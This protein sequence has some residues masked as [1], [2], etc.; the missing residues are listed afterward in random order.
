M[1]ETLTASLPPQLSSLDHVGLHPG[2]PG[3]V[4]GDWNQEFSHGLG[5]AKPAQPA[6]W[7]WGQRL[8]VRNRKTFYPQLEPWLWEGSLF[9]HPHYFGFSGPSLFCACQI[10]GMGRISNTIIKFS[11]HTHTHTT[12]STA[13]S[14]ATQLWD[15]WPSVAQ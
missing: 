10:P 11:I 6:P 2:R 12:T 3:A 13:I 14:F 1:S 7:A 5:L 8:C 15:L 4:G 9:S